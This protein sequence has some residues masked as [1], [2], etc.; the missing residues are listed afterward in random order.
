[1]NILRFWG[2]ISRTSSRIIS[3]LASAV[4]L[5]HP[6]FVSTTLYAIQRMTLLSTTFCLCGLLFYCAGRNRLNGR[7]P[8]GGFYLMSAAVILFTLISTLAKEIGLLLPLMIFILERFA[9]AK[10]NYRLSHQTCTR[11][12]LW[13]RVFLLFPT[14]ILVAL[15][16]NEVVTSLHSYNQIRGVSPLPS[17]C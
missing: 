16:L 12:R 10:F 11:L 4:W 8:A 14:L 17:C 7:N 2:G 6:L 13:V 5:M 1:M 9:F 15:I 3:M